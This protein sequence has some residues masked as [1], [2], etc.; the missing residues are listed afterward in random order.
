MEMCNAVSHY[1]LTRTVFHL[2]PHRNEF[3]THFGLSK[4]ETFEDINSDPYVADQLRNL[5]DHPDFVGKCKR[6]LIISS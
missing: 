6:M 1:F 4:H 3:R 2:T 5:Y